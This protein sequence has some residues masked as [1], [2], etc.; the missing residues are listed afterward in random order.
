MEE[1][2]ILMIK[3]D[4]QTSFFLLAVNKNLVTFIST[5]ISTPACF[6]NKLSLL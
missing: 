2:H 3:E 4:C 1:S 5:E 6:Y